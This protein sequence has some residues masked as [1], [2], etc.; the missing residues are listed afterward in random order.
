MALKLHTGVSTIY[1]TV[2]NVDFVFLNDIIM[3]AAV[4]YRRGR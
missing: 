2:G 4:S 1:N 3:E